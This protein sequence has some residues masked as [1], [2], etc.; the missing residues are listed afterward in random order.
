[1]NS[2]AAAATFVMTAALADLL[3]VMAVQRG[4]RAVRM[5]NGRQRKGVSARAAAY[6]PLPTLMLSSVA[7]ANSPGSSLAPPS[8][9][10]IRQRSSSSR[11]WLP[12]RSLFMVVRRR[13]SCRSPR[14]AEHRVA[15]SPPSRTRI[16]REPAVVDH[17]LAA[18]MLLALEGAVV[19]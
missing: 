9:W 5:S 7:H 17:A 15:S 19:R 12:L 2:S 1:M 3:R 18:A 4:S 13:T 10:Q 14:E 16:H 8:R 6:A 11:M